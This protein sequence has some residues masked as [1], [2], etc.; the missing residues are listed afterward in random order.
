LKPNPWDT[1]VFNADG[2]QI[3]D[4]ELMR[5]IHVVPLLLTIAIVLSIGGTANA[6]QK[7]LG[8]ASAPLIVGEPGWP[9]VATAASGAWADQYPFDPETYG[10]T[11]GHVPA[12]SQSTPTIVFYCRSL[13]PR[14]ME[15]A[16]RVDTLIAPRPELRSSGVYLFDAKGAQAGDYTAAELVER[17]KQIRELADKHKLKT[18]SIAIAANNAPQSTARVGLDDAHDVSIVYFK[19]N[20]DPKKRPVVTWIRGAKSADLDK[21]SLDQIIKSLTT[22]IEPE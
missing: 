14:F 13:D 15:L 2:K 22:A 19:P 5:S 17:I 6:Q 4:T 8:I 3:E 12:A 18:L 16:S 9:G 10:K 21:E 11:R 20:P 1:K 7:P